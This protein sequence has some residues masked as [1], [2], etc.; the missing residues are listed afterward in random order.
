M[1]KI[2]IESCD[3][4]TLIVSSITNFIILKSKMNEKK[5]KTKTENN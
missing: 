4:Y 3:R 5:T 2:K 1:D